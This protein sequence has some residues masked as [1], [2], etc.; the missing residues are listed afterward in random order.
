M[1][2]L[3]LKLRRK[4]LPGNNVNEFSIVSSVCDVSSVLNLACLPDS[5]IG[6]P[7]HQ[8]LSRFST[9]S[10]DDE[11]YARADEVEADGAVNIET[12]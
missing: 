7:D 5:H 6:I 11:L 3:K 2:L 10:K 12:A 9:T 4:C 8:I 1:A